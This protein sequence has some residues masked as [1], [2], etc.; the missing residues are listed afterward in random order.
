[1]REYLFLLLILVI[2]LIVIIA[3]CINFRQYTSLTLPD[4]T[5]PREG[6]TPKYGGF[7]RQ[8][9]IDWDKIEIGKKLG[10]GAWGDVFLAD[11]NGNKYALKKE[12]I[13]PRF[14]TTFSDSM[15]MKFYR[16]IN[17]LPKNEQKYFIKL[18]GWRIYKCDYIHEIPIFLLERAK[19]PKWAKL[20]E[21]YKKSPYC[22]EYLLEYGGKSLMNMIDKIMERGE[23]INIQKMRNITYQVL[24]A[25]QIA[26]KGKFALIDVHAGNVT[27]E[28][29]SIKMVDYGDVG[30]LFPKNDN[31]D[32]LNVIEMMSNAAYL[33][34]RIDLLKRKAPNRIKYIEFIQ[35]QGHWDDVAKYIVKIR[36]EAKP[37]IKKMKKKL[38][39]TDEDYK[40]MSGIGLIHS[41]LYQEECDD[42]HEKVLDMKVKDIPFLLPKEDMLY[43]LEYIDNIPRLLTYFRQLSK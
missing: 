26:H 28:N 43:M 4:D 16:Y 35:D 15:E 36:P 22:A 14:V 2:I 21:K 19:D 24:R 23:K 37:V 27:I 40:K 13:L 29:G 1:M 30:E 38:P 34:K 20:I 3:Y 7:S 32:V 17:K 12:K 11:Y 25:I 31:R 33:F 5:K 10:S 8:K 42:Y 41:I 39:L 18:Y 6:L 9:S